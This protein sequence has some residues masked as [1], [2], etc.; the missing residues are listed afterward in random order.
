MFDDFAP[1]SSTPGARK[2]MGGSVAV[3]TALY[4]GLGALVFGSTAATRHLVREELVQV[5]FARAPEPPPPPPEPPA[6]AAAAE[7]PA[8][9]RPK[10]KRPE[11]KP[12]DKVPEAKPEES[13]APLPDAAPSGPVD[14]FLTGV[15]GGTGHA[16]PRAAPPPPPPPPPP[17][18][19]PL[20]PAVEMKGNPPPPYSN[21]ARRKEIEGTVVVQFDVLENGSVANPKIVSGP[22]ELRDSVLKTIVSWRFVPA[23]RGTQPVRSRQTKSITFRLSDA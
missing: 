12:P 9:L 17:K 22:E 11:L 13:D 14:G 15:E 8:K 4:A 2:R 23:K 3:A 6:P 10:M 7:P 5:E 18:P 16:A 20:T 1:A 19:L 21:S